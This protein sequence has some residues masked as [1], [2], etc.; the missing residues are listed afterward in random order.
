MRAYQPLSEYAPPE[1]RPRPTGPQP[2]P[3]PASSV[4]GAPA[5]V[6]AGFEPLESFTGDIWITDDW[7]SG[8]KRS[9]PESRPDRLPD[10]EGEQVWFV[11]SPWPSLTP[12]QVLNLVWAYLTEDNEPR[13]PE[14][15]REIF[16]WT[17]QRA[18]AVLKQLDLP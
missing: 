3:L 1:P 10:C 8:H 9:L 14:V 12:R 4:I 16:G 2:E 13:W 18:V 11:T 6:A 5:L 7:P 15:R 17:N